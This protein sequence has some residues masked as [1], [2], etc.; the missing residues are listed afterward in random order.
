MDDN[1]MVW[2]FV[3]LVVGGL[4]GAVIGSAK[5]NGGNGFALGCLLGPIGW[6]IA[7]LLDYPRKCPDCQCGVPEGAAVCK[8]CGR[9]LQKR[10]K[11]EETPPTPPSDSER[12]KCP[13]C[14]EFILREAIK[15]RYC[16]SDLPAATIYAG[17]SDGSP[18]HK[19]FGPTPVPRG[20]APQQADQS[21]R[22][23]P[24]APT[25]PAVSS[26]DTLA[27]AHETIPMVEQS[28]P[29]EQ[30]PSASP[31][32]APAEEPVYVKTTCPGCGVKI[33][34]VPFKGWADC[35]GCG[36]RVD[37]SK[38]D[39]N[40]NWFYAQGDSTGGPVSEDQLRGLLTSGTLPP[41]ALV[42]RE[43]LT[44]WLPASECP[45]LLQPSPPPGQPSTLLRPLATG[46]R[47]KGL[48]QLFVRIK[49]REDALN[50]VRG[51]AGL[52]FLVAAW[53]LVIG[54]ALDKNFLTGIPVLL[55]LAFLLLR[56]NSRVSAVL[57]LVL[58]TFGLIVLAVRPSLIGVA[59]GTWL[60]SQVFDTLLRAI[61]VVVTIRAVEAAFKLHGRFR[62]EMAT[63]FREGMHSKAQRTKLSGRDLVKDAL[64]MYYD[65]LGSATKEAWSGLRPGFKVPAIICLVVF[66]AA[67]L[68][69]L[70]TRH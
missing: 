38:T 58:Q 42:W 25:A 26:S 49:T 43:G 56:F 50:W 30:R 51:T 18:T 19:N 5:G 48:A 68:F 67:L 62:I 65:G 2:I 24:Q 39:M 1:L 46:K 60:G 57:L 8:G 31:P 16:G 17:G 55:V 10:D 3:W 28:L 36:L 33:E 59:A 54:L 61:I 66:V 37:L 52:Y 4:V 6:I 29:T 23:R 64:M 14:A 63:E 32:A 15:C 70:L 35:P 9:D 45:P 41:D 27:E 21:P 12:K 22:L 53:H 69:R 11:P 20:S 44:T 34:H 47:G 40:G 7:V 13:F